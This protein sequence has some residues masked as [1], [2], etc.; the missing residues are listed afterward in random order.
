MASFVDKPGVPLLQF[1]D[2]Q[3]DGFPVEQR[4]FYLARVTNDERQAEDVSAGWTVPV[5]E[6]TSSAAVCKLVSSDTAALA[7]ASTGVFYANAGDTGYYRVA[8]TPA[9]VKAITAVAES[10]LTV[11]ERI[12]F[13]GGPVGPD[14]GRDGTGGGTIWT[15]GWR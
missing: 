3:T 15:W 14:A 9:E 1:G 12:G 13:L 5:C 11:A 2:R 7:D 10:G 8:Y 4:R 6:K